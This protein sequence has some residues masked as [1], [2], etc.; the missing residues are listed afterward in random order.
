[1][2]WVFFL[3]KCGGALQPFHFK[4]APNWGFLYLFFTS[5]RLMS[6][7]PVTHG[8]AVFF[9]TD[10]SLIILSIVYISL[11]SKMLLPILQYSVFSSVST[12]VLDDSKWCCCLEPQ[13][14]SSLSDAEGRTLSLSQV[15][16]MDANCKCCSAFTQFHKFGA[17][18]TVITGKHK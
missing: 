5:L 17:L 3:Q 6:L 8:C 12:A 14:L 16:K 9:C 10:F 13:M 1:M 4:K 7:N 11:E 18:V 2:C 15:T